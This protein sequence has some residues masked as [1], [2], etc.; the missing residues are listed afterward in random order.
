M[1]GAAQADGLPGA[2]DNATVKTTT[3]PLLRAPASV[4]PNVAP[5]A[6][7][8]SNQAASQ[9][10]ERQSSDFPDIIVE[11]Y[12]RRTQKLSGGMMAYALGADDMLLPLQDLMILLEFAI[13]ETPG[14]A[15]GWFMAEDR[16]FSLD[17]QAGEVRADGRQF[18]LAPQ[19]ARRIDNQLYVSSRALSQWLPLDFAADP[20]NLTLQINPRERTPMEDR[21][22]RGGDKRYGSV[23]QF[24]SE[25]PKVET[26]YAAAQVP[27]VE[28][29]LTTGASNRR[30]SLAF[31]GGTVRAYGDFLFMNGEAFV[32]GTDRAVVD[33]RMVLGRINPDGGLLGPLNATQYKF[34]DVS[35]TSLPLVS[36]GL[37]GRGVSV[38]SRPLAYLAEFDRITVED[39]IPVNHEVELYRNGIL[40]SSSGPV[41]SGR[42]K[43]DNVPLLRGANE[44]R[45]EYYGPQGQRRTDVKQYFVGN[46]QVP[47]GAFNYD[48][49][50]HDVGRS[51]FGFTNWV[52]DNRLYENT[53]IGGAARFDY[54]LTRN[55]SVTA[56][57]ASTPL[58]LKGGGKDYRTY[59]T[60]GAR[61]LIGNFSVGLDGAVD[62]QKGAAFG[63]SAQ[64]DL[65]GWSLSGRHEQFRNHFASDTSLGTSAATHNYAYRTSN[66]GLRLDTTFA[67]LTPGA[68]YNLGMIGNYTTFDRM[69]ASWRVG[70]TTGASVGRFSLSN[71]LYYGGAMIQGN[72]GVFGSVRANLRLFDGINLR[73]STDYDLRSQAELQGFSFGLTAPLP[74]ETTVGLG[75]SRRYDAYRVQDQ[76]HNEN[77]FATLRRN[78]GVAEVG[79]MASYNRND[80]SQIDQHD[81]KNEYRAGITVSFS[82]FTDPSRGTTVSSERIARQGA[83]RPLAFQDLNQ[84]GVRQGGEPLVDGARVLHAGQREPHYTG[85]NGAPV[86]VGAGVWTDV[87]LDRTGLPDA[88]LAPGSRGVAVLPRP[89]VVAVVP[90]PV[91]AKGGV[92]GHVELRVAGNV[93]PL[94]N[95]KIQIVRQLAAGGE[96]V[97]ADVNTEFDGSFALADVPVGTYILRIEPEQARQIGAKAPVERFVTVD[98]ATGV[99]DGITLILDR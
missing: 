16:T 47:V 64:T 74:F 19:D 48:V 52:R 9:L 21:K 18:K 39:S 40:M 51:V 60:L 97:I 32:T 59:G 12:L 63:L 25:L 71:D 53:G 28:A 3:P 75:Y 96:K 38:S 93:R 29:D 49:S 46:S 76:Q 8:P 69:A 45:L 22:A 58:P 70:A 65:K 7:P 55:M 31:A 43:F 36:G 73:A 33:A 62:D 61:T 80:Q 99:L 41:S 50:L 6:N 95:A 23:Q 14:G 2:W 77:Y 57:V 90:L 91:V 81:L 98:A 34:G 83:I 17:L 13:N 37:S 1:F 20:R 78:F 92:E 35:S 5:P 11:V 86:P 27:A 68:Y 89:G 87:G 67:N 44:I 66:S 79:L 15:A 85:A 30:N 72:R 82:T 42:F 24:R 26:P 54:G 56:G 4:T 10:S 88:A 84:D 94:P